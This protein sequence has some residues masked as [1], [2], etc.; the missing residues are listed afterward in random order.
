MQQDTDLEQKILRRSIFCTLIIATLGITFGILCGS[1][2]IIFDGMFSALDAGMCGLSL[3]VSRLL[4]KP[5]SRRFQY[6]FWHVEPLVL[7][8]NGSLL[9]LLCFYA[10]IN[11]VK[12]IFDGGRELELGWAIAYAAVVSVFCFTLYLKQSRLN[13]KIKSKLIALDTKSWLMSACISSALLV[14]FII[15]WGMEGTRYEYLIVYVDPF[16]LA[17]LTLALIPVP[18]KTVI[19]AVKEVLQMTPDSLDCK[20]ENVMERLTEEYGFLDYSNYAT[21]IGRG[22]FIEI[23]I[24]IPEEM[25]KIGVLQFDKIRDEIASEITERGPYLWLTISFTRDPKWL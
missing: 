8:F 3:L 10:F 21:R 24:V 23:H 2:S 14:A 18:V 12:G 7:A 13:R 22:L 19:S 6:G 15:S 20:V 1:L 4:T 17:V 16:V 5:L 11:A 25:E 9:V